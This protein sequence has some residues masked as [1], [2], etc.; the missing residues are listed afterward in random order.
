MTTK[1]ELN[2]FEMDIDGQYVPTIDG[3]LD[4]SFSLIGSNL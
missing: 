4:P 3:C 2:N 1:L